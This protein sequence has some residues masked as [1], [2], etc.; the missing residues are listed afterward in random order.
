MLAVG[1]VVSMLAAQAFVTEEKKGDTLRTNHSGEKISHLPESKLDDVGV[2]GGAFRAV[3]AGEVVG[4]SVTVV[5]AVGEVVLVVVADEII[6]RE[7]IMRRDHVDARIRSAMIV[8]KDALAPGDAGGKFSQHIVAPPEAPHSVAKFSVQF[9][10]VGGKISDLVTARAEVPGL[11]YE[12]GAA[13]HRVLVD[14]LKESGPPL[15]GVRRAS[16][17]HSE[18]EAESVHVHFRDPVAQAVHHR[19]QGAGMGN[20]HR[21]AAAGVVAVVPR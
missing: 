12:L 18:V 1:V 9:A 7:T 10:P 13:E 2:V 5:L 21:V 6:Q 8:G 14:G 19:L 17:F 3:I 4:V 16:H 15:E 20:I 11:G